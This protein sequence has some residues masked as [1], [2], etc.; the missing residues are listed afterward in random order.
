[1]NIAGRVFLGIGK[2]RSTD[3]TMTIVAC[4]TLAAASVATTPGD[5]PART[6]YDASATESTLAGDLPADW[7][8][9]LKAMPKLRKLTVCRPDLTHFKVARLKDLPQLT[10]FRAE[11][12]PLESRLADAVALNIAK[13]PG[14]QSVMFVRTGLTRRGLGWLR[15][16]PI[17]ALVLQ[18]EEF[19]TD[20][21]FEHVA[22]MNSLRTLVLEATPIDGTGL[23]HLQGCSQLRSLVLRRHPAGSTDHGA[24]ERLAALAGI[25]QLEELEIESTDYARLVV[26][27][28]IPSLK[29]LTLR[30]CGAKAAS[31]S[32]KQL[33]QLDTL[34]LDNCDVRN[35]TFADLKATLAEVGIE[36]VDATPEATTDVLTRDSSPMNEATKLARQLHDQLDIAKHHPTFW[37]RWSSYSND[38]PSM[39]AEPIRTV[40]RLKKALSEKHV[41]Q[42]HAQDTIMAWAPGQFYVREESSNDGVAI[43][44]QI[45]YGG[46]KVA[47]ARERRPG[48]PPG[49]VIRSGVSEFV[50]SLFNIPP[51]LRTSHQSYWWGAGTHHTVAT[52][53]V[54]PRRAAYQE[55][56]AEDFAGE[57]CRVL[58]SAGR[59]ERLWI[60]KETGLLR[61]SLSFI[62]QGYFIPFY[63]Q[64][65]VTQIAGRPVTSH[66][67]Y[68]ALFGQGEDALPEVKQRML[69]QAWSEYSFDHAVPYHLDVFGDYRQV[70]TGLWFPFRVES[71]GW[72]HNGKN[73]GRYDFYSFEKIIT[74]VAVDRDDLHEYWADAL[75]KK[76]EVVQ[77]QRH[78]P[79]L[80]YRYGDDRTGDELP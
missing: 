11:D 70:A 17:A 78:Q 48:D 77:D 68:R 60:S 10:S 54:L 74:E 36:V 13:L 56:P 12:F 51:Q 58:E 59:S 32:L 25:G 26:L 40:Y 61:G 14:L 79:A 37:I 30:R 38:V 7:L 28:Q 57:H 24:D 34:V 44:E 1:M 64:N 63:Q 66:D 3:P 69:S 55:L 52:S 65:V 76:G 39:K 75:P 46:A 5:A 45:K 73:E 21:A 15:D 62:H 50:E 2:N 29:K 41:R 42:P 22:K 71:A 9:R 33:T 72:H 6:E 31:Q 47:W 53:S 4:L 16:S 67:D 49:H 8:E 27:K 20:D 80:E 35:E 43:W 18:E 19:L 23:A